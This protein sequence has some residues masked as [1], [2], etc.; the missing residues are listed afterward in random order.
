L[1]LHPLYWDLGKLIT[2]KQQ[3]AGWGDA[4][5]EQVARDLTR[6]L[7]GV[8]GFWLFGISCGTIRQLN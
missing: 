1:G 3:A 6:E 5:I 2:E 8:K 4:V 7:D